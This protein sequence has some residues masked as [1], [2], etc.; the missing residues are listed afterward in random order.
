MRAFLALEIPSE[1]KSYLE[2]VVSGMAARVKGVRWV[3]RNGLH[4]TLK[5]LG[6]I[7]EE[8]AIRIKDALSRVGTV[9]TPFGTSIKEIDAFP[10]RRRARVVVTTLGEG[11]DTIKSIFGD[12][13]KGLSKLN[14][15]AE[16]RPYT[17]HITLGRAKAP[18][19]LP[20]KDV[21]PLEARRFSVD[22]V[23]LFRSTLA[24]EGAIYTP[25]W[26]IKLGG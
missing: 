23:V 2:A 7:E 18:A 20:D 3:K 22:R 25:V 26:D 10:N 5:F 19:P 1:V 11:V 8:T 14:F 24:K 9:Y 16:E 17:P 15:E 13:E 12:A 6:E 4:I 21:A